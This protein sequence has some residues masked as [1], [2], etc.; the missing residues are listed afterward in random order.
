[1]DCSCNTAESSELTV[2]V[3]LLHLVDCSCNTA[4]SSASSG[5]TVLVIRLHM[6]LHV[7]CT[8]DLLLP[9]HSPKTHLD[10][11]HLYFKMQKL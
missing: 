6:P 9:A 1:M 7:L 10:A 3:T 11:G 4:A 8:P 2:L 5:L